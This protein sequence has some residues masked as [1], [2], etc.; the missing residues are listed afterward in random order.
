MEAILHSELKFINLTKLILLWYFANDPPRV[1]SN[2]K[3]G[4][5]YVTA[6]FVKDLLT[7]AFMFIFM[8]L[9]VLL[10]FL[11]KPII[12]ATVAQRLDDLRSA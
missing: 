1:Y 8:L 7:A 3:V 6:T 12:I 10:F 5:W 9:C 4:G 11:F 2:L